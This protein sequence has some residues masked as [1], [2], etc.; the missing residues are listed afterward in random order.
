MSS[1]VAI[2]VTALLLTGAAIWVLIAATAIG[3][4]LDW[5]WKTIR[6]RHT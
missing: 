4:T 5:L 2:I 6:G 3:V 1:A